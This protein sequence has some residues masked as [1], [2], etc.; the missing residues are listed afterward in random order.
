M[1]SAPCSSGTLNH[2]SMIRTLRITGWELNAKTVD[3]IAN[4]DLKMT[5]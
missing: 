3:G 4:E 2:H 5:P 1:A